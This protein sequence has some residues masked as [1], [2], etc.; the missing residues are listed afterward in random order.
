[1]RAREKRRLFCA[2]V[3]GGQTVCR[4]VAA[5][6]P[7]RGSACTSNEIFWPSLRLWITARSIDEMFWT[8]VE[9]VQC[10]AL[11]GQNVNEHIGFAVVLNDEAVTFLGIEE[12]NDTCGHQWPPVKTRNGVITRA[13]YLAWVLISGILQ[14]AI[15]GHRYR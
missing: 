2:G 1:M 14:E 4:F 9:F 6:L 5:D 12:F 3:A 15:D 13:N 7:L 11:A 10:A 8:L